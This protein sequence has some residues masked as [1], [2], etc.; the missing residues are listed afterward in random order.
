MKQAA[1]VLIEQN[2][3]YLAVSRRDNPDDFGLP[4]GKLDPG[5][6]FKEAVLRETLEE[7]VI[8]EG[9]DP[10]QHSLQL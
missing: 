1:T 9:E 8:S 2:G 10:K 6:T 5:E 3:L 7:D 4:G